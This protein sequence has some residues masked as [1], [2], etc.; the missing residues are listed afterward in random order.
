[1]KDYWVPLILFYTSFRY[2]KLL[3][4][5]WIINFDESKILMIKII[6]MHFEQRNTYIHKYYREITNY[7]VAEA[8]PVHCYNFFS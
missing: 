1:M 5:F 6:E 2:I 4:T 8:T 7:Y 3:S